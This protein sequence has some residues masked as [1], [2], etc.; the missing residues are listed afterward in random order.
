MPPLKNQLKNLIF[1][2]YD[3][4]RGDN[5]YLSDISSIFIVRNYSENTQ[6][7][8]INYAETS[9]KYTGNSLNNDNPIQRTENADN[10]NYW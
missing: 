9:H 7:Q 4:N 8:L 1:L 2:L 5:L 6:E 3:K 10:R